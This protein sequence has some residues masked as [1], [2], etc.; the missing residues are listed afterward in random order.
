MNFTSVTLLPPPTP[1][2]VIIPTS[3]LCSCNSWF[4]ALC[5]DFKMTANFSEKAPCVPLC[6]MYPADQ[7]SSFN[8]ECEHIIS[9]KADRVFK[10][11]THNKAV[12]LFTV[13]YYFS[14]FK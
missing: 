8:Y 14:N 11:A 1:N 13:P 4:D 10:M 3:F 7:D 12:P 5:L 9:G 6:L 2:F